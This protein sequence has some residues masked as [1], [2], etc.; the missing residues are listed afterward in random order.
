MTRL[1]MTSIFTLTAFIAVYGYPGS[2]QLHRVARSPYYGGFGFHP[3]PPFP[4]FQTKNWSGITKSADGN[5]NGVYSGAA[6][7]ATN[8]APAT[9]QAVSL[10]SADCDDDAD[11]VQST[12]TSGKLIAGFGDGH[13]GDIFGKQYNAHKEAR[14]LFQS[15]DGKFE[16]G[17]NA[18]S[19]QKN[20]GLAQSEFGKDD[21]TLGFTQNEEQSRGSGQNIEQYGLPSQQGGGLSQQDSALSQKTLSSS[22]G[23]QNGQLKEQQVG[24]NG[25]YRQQTLEIGS[26]QQKE[27]AG[28]A[29]QQNQGAFAQSQG[30]VGFGQHVDQGGFNVQQG[31]ATLNQKEQHLGAFGQSQGQ[32]GFG[33]HE[34]HGGVNVQQGQASLSQEEQLKQQNLQGR[35]IASSQASSYAHGRGFGYGKGFS[36]YGH[37]H[38]YGNDFNSKYQAN[39]DLQQQQSGPELTSGKSGSQSAG[40][41]SI[42]GALNLAS[43][44]LEAA[45]KAG[46]STCG[47]NGGYAF[48]NAKSHSGSAISV[49]IGG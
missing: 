3:P 20:T 34:G 15:G 14:Y 48:S 23:Q 11:S 18:E 10:A 6:A 33:Q 36:G 46:C 12:G 38:S 28:V 2:I 13:R 31:Q 4:F 42:G 22:F 26:A 45:Q 29:Q 41:S 9:G 17:F 16:A 47:G 40:S 37:D 1:M 39:Q 8:N 7:S 44:G 24:L 25:G 43:Q 21:H 5:T 30:Q 32:V 35:N 49:A 27:L 19:G